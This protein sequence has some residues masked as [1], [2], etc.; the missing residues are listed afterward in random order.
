MSPDDLTQAVQGA[1]AG[2]LSENG[3]FMEGITGI[4]NYVDDD[5]NRRWETIIPADQH[6]DITVGMAEHLLAYLKEM[7]SAH[8]RAVLHDEGHI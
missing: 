4:V 2:A 6:G 1:A 8:L 7:R 3:W 5:G